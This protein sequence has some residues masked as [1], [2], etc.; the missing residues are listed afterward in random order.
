M[1]EHLTGFSYTNLTLIQVYKYEATFYYH[2]SESEMKMSGFPTLLKALVKIH[3][4]K[5]LNCKNLLIFATPICKNSKIQNKILNLC[6]KAIF[7]SLVPRRQCH[8]YIW[9]W[10]SF[11]SFTYIYTYIYTIKSYIQNAFR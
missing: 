6:Y 10:R 2:I 11:T 7:N 4:K 9:L 3:T 8:V 5:V 1:K